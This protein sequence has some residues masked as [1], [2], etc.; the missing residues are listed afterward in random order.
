MHHQIRSNQ[1]AVAAYWLGAV[2]HERE[3]IHRYLGM[4]ALEEYQPMDQCRGN[5]SSTYEPGDLTSGL[6]NDQWLWTITHLPS[7]RR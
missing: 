6:M 5:T 4:F 3:L 2:S 1:P 7:T